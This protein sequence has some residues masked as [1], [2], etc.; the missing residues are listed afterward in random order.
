[1][2][3]EEGEKWIVSLIRETRSDAKIDFNKVY[4]FHITLTTKGI[5]IM[6]HPNQSVYQQVIERTKGLYLDST[7]MVQSIK[8]LQSHVSSKE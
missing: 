1:L 7:V 8:T 3:P 6:N 4:P 2:S 5:V